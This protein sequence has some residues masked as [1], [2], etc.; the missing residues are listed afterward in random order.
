[1]CGSC[2]ARHAHAPLS[3]SDGTG[4]SAGGDLAPEPRGSGIGS[5]AAQLE[6]WLARSRR[7]RGGR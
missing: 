4:G 1:V 6:A 5:A 7:G 3:T 2:C